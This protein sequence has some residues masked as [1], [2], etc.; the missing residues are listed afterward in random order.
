[1]RDDGQILTTPPPANQAYEVEGPWTGPID[2]LG[3]RGLYLNLTF[4]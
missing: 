2:L 1:V 4:E 3:T